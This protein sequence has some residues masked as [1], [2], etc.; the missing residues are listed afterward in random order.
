MK[1]ITLLLVFFGLISIQCTHAQLQVVQNEGHKL[2]ISASLFSEDDKTFYTGGWDG[3][4]KVWDRESFK[5]IK[6]LIG[7]KEKVSELLF[8]GDKLVSI[9]SYEMNIWNLEKESK[10]VL[11]FNDI[12]V[13]GWADKSS[14]YAVGQRGLYQYSLS[15]GRYKS[16]QI[17]TPKYSIQD[18]IQRDSTSAWI[19]YERSLVLVNFRNG[20]IIKEIPLPRIDMI[21]ELSLSHDRSKFICAGMNQIYVY[22]NQTLEYE[23]IVGKA[24]NSGAIVDG[25]LFGIQYNKIDVLSFNLGED[26][27]SERFEHS[28]MSVKHLM[29]SNN[30]KYLLGYN[31]S[32]MILWDVKTKSKLHEFK[33]SKLAVA[34][35]SINQ[36]SFS[37]GVGS[38]GESRLF[39]LKTLQF[40]TKQKNHF[41]SVA[42][43]LLSEKNYWEFCDD[44]V[45]LKIDKQSGFIKDSFNIEKPGQK[46][47]IRRVKS[48]ME[49]LSEGLFDEHVH[50]AIE[51][52]KK[53]ILQL[54]NDIK[55]YD[56]KKRQYKVLKKHEDYVKDLSL[57]P[58]N[59]SFLS[60][61][62]DKMVYLW[63]L[64]KGKVEAEMKGHSDRVFAVDAINDYYFVSGSANGELAQWLN[65]KDQYYYQFDKLQGAIYDITSNDKYFLVAH[66]N[67]I[68]QYSSE[69]YK[70]VKDVLIGIT[71]IKYLEFING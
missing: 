55:V 52:D 46:L 42:A 39:N 8:V 58:N 26:I 51:T 61:G 68:V 50:Q 64:K 54:N 2:M 14:I 17:F 15:Y 31:Y 12:A 48:A 35:I 69:T 19:A 23:G 30:G 57:L 27:I 56:K 49:M 65:H 6:T 7:H 44:N 63:N 1:A 40:E 20:T 53:I 32:T 24:H 47:P 37:C 16:K 11:N 71:P 10:T 70:K 29:L 60:A 36:N 28:E 21:Q 9:G 62:L 13:G 59:E 43:T 67:G 5:E 22:D 45:A 33:R 25:K 4:I 41:Q 38:Q 3:K 66:E 34:G 18:A